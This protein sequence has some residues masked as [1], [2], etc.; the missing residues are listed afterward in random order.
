MAGCPHGVFSPNSYL[1]HWHM[2]V[3]SHI[4]AD[5]HTMH[6]HG[7]MKHQW[8]YPLPCPILGWQ[9]TAPWHRELWTQPRE[10]V[11]FS[12]NSSGPPKQGLLLPTIAF[13]L[14]LPI[15]RGW[16]TGG[17]PT[18]EP[19]PPEWALLSRASSQM[20][21]KWYLQ[22]FLSGGIFHINVLLFT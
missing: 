2:P 6:T 17:C 10:L 16:G 1:Y 14:L 9:S 22:Y 19:A 4:C 8:L 7:V 20:Q 21:T 13:I 15:P 11:P 3:L 18:A 5:F 12:K